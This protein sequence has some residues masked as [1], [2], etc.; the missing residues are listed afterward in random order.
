MPE[1]CHLAEI[2]LGF[3]LRAFDVD[4]VV[5]CDAQSG[6]ARILIWHFL[7]LI[8]IVLIVSGAE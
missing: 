2:I 5:R 1:N 3:P 7:L 8:R 4:A 6:F